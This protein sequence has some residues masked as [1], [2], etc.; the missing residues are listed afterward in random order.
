MLAANIDPSRSDAGAPLTRAHKPF[1]QWRRYVLDNDSDAD[2]IARELR[3]LHFTSAGHS[4]E[5]IGFEAGND[6][7]TVLATTP[8][9]AETM[10]ERRT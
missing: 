2:A 5:L 3:A 4:H 1:A 9:T 6:A 8:S 10:R 7:P